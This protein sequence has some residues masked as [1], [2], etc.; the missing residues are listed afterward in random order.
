MLKS[1]SFMISFLV[2]LVTSF[3]SFIVRYVIKTYSGIDLF[4]VVDNPAISFLS[5]LVLTLSD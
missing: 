2:V 1:K 4:N 5:G 3:I